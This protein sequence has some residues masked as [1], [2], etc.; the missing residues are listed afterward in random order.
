MRF[1][2]LAIV[3]LLACDGASS[4]KA[5]AAYDV[6]STGHIT[7]VDAKSGQQICEATVTATLG[8]QSVMLRP[9]A[10]PIA[11][12]MGPPPGVFATLMGPPFRQGHG[13][14]RNAA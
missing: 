13:A 7:L 14:T 10:V 8:S 4:S 5:C 1:L 2:V 3:A 11:T 6:A 9:Q 12:L